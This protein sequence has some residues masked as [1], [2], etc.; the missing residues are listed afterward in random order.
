MQKIIQIKKAGVYLP[1]G[2]SQ[3]IGEINKVV[4]IINN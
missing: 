1:C 3:N 4:K 2:P